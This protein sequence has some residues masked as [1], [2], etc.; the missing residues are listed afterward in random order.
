MID[1]KLIRDLG[2][3][4]ERLR[5][6][7][8]KQEARATRITT[9]VSG[10]PRGGGNPKQTE[11][12][13]IQLAM[14]RDQHQEIKAELDGRRAEL[15]TRMRRIRNGVQRT[16]LVMRYM[17]NAKIGD[18]MDVL[19]YSRSQVIRILGKAEE[20]INRETGRKNVEHHDT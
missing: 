9:S 6:A 18:I 13:I 15:R 1:F 2:K 19:N 20:I 10:M 3:Q 12:E 8:I 5:M 11:D 14:I 7:V 4:E 16:A 17:Q